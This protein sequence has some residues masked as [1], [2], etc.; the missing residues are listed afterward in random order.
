MRYVLLSL[1]PACTAGSRK[2]EEQSLSANEKR[3]ITVSVDS[4]THSYLDAMAARDASRT[5]AHFANDSEFL[6]YFDATPMNYEAVSKAVRGT[7]GGLSAIDIQ[8]VTVSVTVLGPNAAIAGFSFHEA[9]TD[10]AKKVSRL[11]GTVSWTW[12]R[13][14]NGWKIIHGD[15]VHLSDTTRSSP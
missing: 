8:P 13:Q 5:I 7:F 4:A 3:A 10:T 11:R 12:R 14:G 6:A 2:V 15:A 1:L 9:Y